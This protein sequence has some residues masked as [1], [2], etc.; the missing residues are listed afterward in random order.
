[1]TPTESW[2]SPR[3]RRLLACQPARPPAC[4]PSLGSESR[5]YNR[6]IVAVFIVITTLLLLLI[7]V[8]VEIILVPQTSHSNSVSA[9][10]PSFSVTICQSFAGCNR[11]AQGF[12]SVTI[13]SCHF[14]SLFLFL[15]VCNYPF[16]SLSSSRAYHSDSFR[17]SPNY[18]LLSLIYTERQSKN[19]LLAFISTFPPPLPFILMLRAYYL[20]FNSSCGSKTEEVVVV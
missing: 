8:V 3:T 17:L 18:H 15:S 4:L 13:S 7:I 14:P 1:M 19:E 9:S 16:K 20:D 6:H 12:P 11:S 10:S 5:H 2:N